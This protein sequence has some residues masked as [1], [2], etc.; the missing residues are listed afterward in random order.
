VKIWILTSSFPAN[1]GDARAAA[2][3]FVA[4]FAVA[5]AEAG[6]QVSVVTPDKQ[7]GEKRDP[8]GVRVHWFAW[9]GGR[10]PLSTLRPYLPAD[11]LAILSLFRRGAQALE[12]LYRREA[13][14]HVL[15]MW[16]AP[17]GIL[18]VWLKR[19]RGVPVTTWC[20]GSDIWTL[21]RYPILRGVVR[22]VL[23]ASSFVFADGVQLAEDAEKLAGR[24]CGFMPSSRRLDRA[25]DRRLSPSEAG[26]RFL[27]IGRYARVKGVDVLLEAMA[28]FSRREPSGH[29]YL[30][31]GGP[32]EAQIRRRAGGSDL[33]GRV[34]IGAWADEATAVSWL[35]ASDCVVIPSRMESIP[36]IFSDAIQMGRPLIV[37]DVGDMGRLL[38]E[39]PAGLVVPP[40]DPSALCA[41]MLQMAAQDRDRYTPRIQELAAQFDVARVA[42]AWIRRVQSAPSSQ[43]PSPQSSP[44]PPGAG[45]SFSASRS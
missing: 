40:E 15:A 1:P 39:H 36:V 18:A 7:S 14:D 28:E 16:A 31:G 4:D 33:R 22:R 9:R 17:S 3:L 11:G 42:A 8:P 45:G 12:E 34:T 6:H 32:L 44:R 35:A 38:R 26:V 20:L 13:P 21:G 43:E 10:K 23:R 37:S 25:L 5:L 2:G 29:L 24:S 41:A 30:F 19:R 27:F